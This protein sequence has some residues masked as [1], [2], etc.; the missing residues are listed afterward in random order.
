MCGIAGVSGPN[1][2]VTALQLILGQL[3][4]GTLGCGVAF[5]QGRRDNPRIAVLK[6][7]IHPIQFVGKYF[8]RLDRRS[9]SA[10]AHNRW[11]SKGSVSYVNTHPFMACNRGFAIVHNGTTYFKKLTIQKIKR[12]HQI[13]GDTDSE[14]ICH[15]VEQYYNMHGDM[16]TALAELSDTEFSGSVLVLL[17]NGE[18]YGLRKG[19]EPIHYCV[20]DSHVLIASSE[21]AI[22]NLVNKRAEIRRLKSGQIIKASGLNVSIHDTD[23]VTDH[24]WGD[25]YGLTCEADYPY[26]WRHYF[27]KANTL[28]FVF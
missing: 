1:A 19:F 28:K 23:H 9:L 7:P 4:R 14:V 6:S 26:S 11:P 20:T 21:N 10:V 5:T 27:R 22:R 16:V 3:E 12:G 18:L 8:A 25:L 15:I 2:P 24:Y 17:K 13:L